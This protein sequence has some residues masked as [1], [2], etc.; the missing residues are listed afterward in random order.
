MSLNGINFNSHDS[1]PT[2][3]NIEENNN[4]SKLILD[5]NVEL[6]KDGYEKGIFNSFHTTKEHYESGGSFSNIGIKQPNI[7][8][9]DLPNGTDQ[10]NSEAI[11]FDPFLSSYSLPSSSHSSFSSDCPSSPNNSISSNHERK[12]NPEVSS[13]S[14]SPFFPTGVPYPPPPVPFVFS[15]PFYF[16]PEYTTS[17]LNYIP[18]SFPTP[19]NQPKKPP[20]SQK[21]V[22]DGDGKEFML[23]PNMS[24]F[25]LPTSKLKEFRNV[26]TRC[27]MTGHNSRNCPLEDMRHCFICD[28]VGHLAKTC[29]NIVPK[30]QK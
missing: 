11:P 3:Y 21:S 27:R 20:S 8:F 2:Q 9:T 13:K 4:E 24:L 16:L 14:L 7:K 23:G 25:D 18:L 26:C 5:N 28:Q 22:L 1:F 19:I 17:Y 10:S 6:L 29:P 30:I 15:S 12:T